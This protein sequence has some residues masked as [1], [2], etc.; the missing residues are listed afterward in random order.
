[1]CGLHSALQLQ[2]V[3]GVGGGVDLLLVVGFVDSVIDPVGPVGEGEVVGEQRVFD[4]GVRPLV[5]LGHRLR[6]YDLDVGLSHFFVFFFR[7]DLSIITNLI[8]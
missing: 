7:F 2:N 6:V 8:L 3:V 4:L 5:D 1:M